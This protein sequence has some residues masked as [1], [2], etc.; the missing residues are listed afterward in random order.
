MNRSPGE[1][2][3]R[4]QDSGSQDTGAHSPPNPQPPEASDFEASSW[5]G[6]RRSLIRGGEYI[7]T[8]QYHLSG[9]RWA[10]GDRAIPA[11]RPQAGAR[12]PSRGLNIPPTRLWTAPADDGSDRLGTNTGAG[13]ASVLSVH[14]VA[15]PRPRPA[16][17]K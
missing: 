14:R 13:P 8:A 12:K 5:G 3:F 6:G 15:T 1:G 7:G 10:L 17:S 2:C 9:K 16:Q 11:S 4:R